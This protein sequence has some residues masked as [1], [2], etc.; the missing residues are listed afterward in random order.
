MW[1]CS[2]A[3]NWQWLPNLGQWDVPGAMPPMSLSPERG[4]ALTRPSP[5]PF[6]LPA[7]LAKPWVVWLSVTAHSHG[8][9]VKNPLPMPGMATLGMC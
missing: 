8:E 3:Q 6:L 2:L 5:V 7:T 9:C 4:H 1:L